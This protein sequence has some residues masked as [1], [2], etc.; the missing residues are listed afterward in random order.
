[1]RPLLK[2]IVMNFTDLAQKNVDH[3]NNHKT[4]HNIITVVGTIVAIAVIG[5]F[6]KKIAGADKFDN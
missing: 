2:G 6:C 4:T 1:M 5:V 3:Y